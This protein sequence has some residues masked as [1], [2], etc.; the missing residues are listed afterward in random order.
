MI[1]LVYLQLDNHAGG[2]GDYFA[3][4]FAV[5]FCFDGHEVPEKGWIKIC[6]GDR[7][8]QLTQF[9]IPSHWHE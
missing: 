6:R 2:F 4:A 7:R 9:S 8:R 3:L 1:I 5:I